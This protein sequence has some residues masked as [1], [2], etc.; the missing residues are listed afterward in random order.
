MTMKS[1]LQIS[2]GIILLL[3]F[4]LTGS[5]AQ[6]P[7]VPPVQT[8]DPVTGLPIS[9]PAP[10]SD[11]KDTNW[12]DP[13]I[14]LTNVTYRHLLLSEVAQNLRQQ[15]KEQFDVLLPSDW[16]GAAVN[17]ATGLPVQSLDWK[18]LPIDLQL[19]NVTAS[20]VFGAMNL[21]FENDR[22]PLR[23]ELKM[24]GRRPIARLTV[25]AEPRLSESPPHQRRVY[26]VGDLIGDEKSGGMKIDGIL[27]AILSVWKMSEMPH[28]ADIKFHESAQ[29]VIVTGTPD[30]IDFVEQTLTALRQK[31]DLARK[32]QSRPTEFKAGGSSGSK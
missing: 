21:I 23:W 19:K 9:P 15:F 27:D 10:G 13:D 16:S 12:V 18:G 30:Q 28:G 7:G 20:E 31:V 29:L 14:L 22:T 4:S 11:W 17:P 24:L 26:F 3:A 2:A 1:K 25:L 32:Q 8:I 6:T 5:L